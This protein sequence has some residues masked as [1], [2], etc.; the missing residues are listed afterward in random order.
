MSCY[1]YE[2][3]ALYP[4][5]LRLCM[6]WNLCMICW[7]YCFSMILPFFC[8]YSAYTLVVHFHFTLALLFLN[9]SLSTIF[10]RPFEFCYFYCI[11]PRILFWILCFVVRQ[12]EEDEA[13]RENREKERYSAKEKRERRKEREKET[14]VNPR[15]NQSNKDWVFHFCI[16][17]QSRQ[18]HLFGRQRNWI[19]SNK[20]AIGIAKSERGNQN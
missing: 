8:S 13:K 16:L 2:N 5:A 7:A 1:T 4:C 15:V 3:S 9:V 12:Q 11:S 6:R 20:N 18:T 19:K 10:V 14:R 17:C